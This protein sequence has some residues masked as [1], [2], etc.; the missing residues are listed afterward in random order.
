MTVTVGQLND[1]S[2]DECAELL[3][4]CCGSQR[5][6]SRMADQRP[7]TSLDDVLRTA[8]H[9]WWAVDAGDWLEA[10]MHHPPIGGTQSVSPQSERA[11]SWSVGE[12]AGVST[13]APSAKSELAAVNEAYLAKFGFIYIV[14]AAGK[15]ADELLDIARSRLGNNRDN[16][17]RVAA[18]EQRKITKLRL[19]KLITD[20]E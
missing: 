10:F 6:V 16:E 1:L 8:E 12:Q 15:S 17:L 3:A 20:G 11:A 9:V 18:E 2:N 19:Q 14:S 5:W 13:A 7:F 4:A